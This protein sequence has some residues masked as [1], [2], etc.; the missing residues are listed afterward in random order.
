[1]SPD[2]W[3]LASVRRFFL[4]GS[5][6]TQKRMKTYINLYPRI[7]AYESLH[8]AWRNAARRK[9]RSAGVASFEYALTDNLLQLEEELQTQTY[10]PGA[11]TH[12]RITSPKP[13]LISA[14]PFRDRVVHHALVQQIEPIF[15]ARFS[16][17]SYACRVGKG[18]HAALHR[19]RE[20]ARRYPY[21]LQCDV[22]QFFPALDHALLRNI[23]F[24]TIADEQTRWLIDQILASG[25]G[26]LIYA[27]SP[28]AHWI[29]PILPQRCAD[30]WRTRPTVIPTAC[31]GR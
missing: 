25:E 28:L 4:I 30:G 17:D 24:R 7:W 15:E 14:A 18:T 9:R 21:V 19:C 13:R 8:T 23:L 16:R 22:V 10:R 27:G 2:F 3:L 20:F 5:G 1:L 6:E 29:T 31:G 12:F 11:Y 26:V